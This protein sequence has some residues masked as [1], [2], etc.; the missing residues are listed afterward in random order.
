M[1]I[2]FEIDE[3][4]A[5]AA[6]L[7]VRSKLLRLASSVGRREFS[8]PNFFAGTPRPASQESRDHTR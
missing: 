4:A 8:T 7:E 5:K 2:R 1:A 3:R 6:G